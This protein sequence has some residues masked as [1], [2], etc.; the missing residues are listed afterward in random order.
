MKKCAI[1][2]FFASFFYFL[3]FLVTASP[4]RFFPSDDIYYYELISKVRFL[5]IL[6]AIINSYQPVEVISLYISKIIWSWLSNDPL[7][8]FLFQVV[9]ANSAILFLLAMILFFITRNPIAV[10]IGIILFAT[11]VWPLNYSLCYSYMPFATMLSMASLFLMFLAYSDVK[12]RYLFIA[13]SGI[14]C[15]LFFWSSPSALIMITCYV[16]FSFYLFNAISKKNNQKFVMKYLLSMTAAIAPFF[17][18]SFPQLIRH[19]NGNVFTYHYTDAYAKFKH[20]PHL[21]FFTFFD[22]LRVYNGFL[23][24]SFFIIVSLFIFLLIQKQAFLEKITFLKEEKIVI[25]LL[26][27]LFLYFLFMD[28]LPF[29]KSARA[30]FIIYPIFLVVLVSMFYFGTLRLSYPYR[31]IWFW[32]LAILLLAAVSA[33]IK[34]SSELM[35]VTKYTPNFLSLNCPNMSICVLRGDS[36]AKYITLWLGNDFDIELINSDQTKAEFLRAKKCALVIG[37]T[38]PG[39]GC[40]ILYHSCLADYSITNLDSYVTANKL[41]RIILP[42]YAYFPSF[43]LEEEISQALYFLRQVPNYKTESKNLTLLLYGPPETV[44]SNQ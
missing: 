6:K 17:L 14:I 5:E 26:L 21:T 34:F 2:S 9:G 31:K 42:Y 16:L 7:S 13:L 27:I 40:S 22:I 43:L 32:I 38:G 11:S 18:K 19:F 25:A 29:T 4:Y 35:Y 44:L 23:L 41:K 30:Y 39:S 28:I 36:H 20:V 33:N 1:F 24:F 15:G 12:R 8:V 3:T 37:P 10:T